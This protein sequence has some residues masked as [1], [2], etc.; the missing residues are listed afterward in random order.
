MSFVVETLPRARE[1]IFRTVDRLLS[2]SQQGAQSW[3][4]ALDHARDELRESAEMFAV[5]PESKKL[6]VLLHHRLFHTPQGLNYQLVYRIDRAS[7][8]VLIY[9]MLA[10]GQRSLRRRDL[11]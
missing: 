11:P 4:D 5:L 6:G 2:H 9:R 3:I 1:D 10:P 8:T 7:S